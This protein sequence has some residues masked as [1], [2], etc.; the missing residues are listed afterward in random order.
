MEDIPWP[1]LLQSVL[2]VVPPLSVYDLIIAR[3]V[4]SDASLYIVENSFWRAASPPAFWSSA[5]WSSGWI[6]WQ[7][8]DGEN[9]VDKENRGKEGILTGSFDSSSSSSTTVS[10]FFLFGLGLSTGISFTKGW[11]GCDDGPERWVSPFERRV[12][13]L[14]PSDFANFNSIYLI[15]FQFRNELRWADLGR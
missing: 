7:E 6:E 13:Q 8:P 10:Q 12:G 4:S 2:S 14:I 15:S 5:V 9:L 1:I 3:L 11:M